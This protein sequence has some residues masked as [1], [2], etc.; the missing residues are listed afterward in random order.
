M[1]KTD[2]FFM[3]EAIT[4]AQKAVV[5]GDF[6][7]GAVL[8]LDDKIVARARNRGYSTKNRLAHAEMQILESSRELLEKHKGEATL[9]TTYEPCPMCFGAIVLMKLKRVVTGTNIDES[10]CLDLQQCLPTYWQQDK[11]TFEI[12]RNVLSEECKAVFLNG[13]M[14]GDYDKFL[15]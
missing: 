6:P 3:S 9:Y 13:K 7:I 11:F 8:V 2:K 5:T 12:T 4:E 14:S 15:V 1:P 10:G